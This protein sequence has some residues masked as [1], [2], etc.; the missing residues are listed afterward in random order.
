MGIQRFKMDVLITKSERDEPIAWIDGRSYRIGRSTA[1]CI[2][3]SCRKTNCK[4]KLKMDHVYHNPILQGVHLPT[5]LQ[6]TA[7]YV[8]IEIF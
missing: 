7:G 3:W 4:G 8:Q 2:S 1:V 5:C 6:D